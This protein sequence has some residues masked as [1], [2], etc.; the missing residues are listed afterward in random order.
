MRNRLHNRRMTP[1]HASSTARHASWWLV[2]CLAGCGGSP[3]ADP[4]VA[5][6]LRALSDRDGQIEWQAMLPCADCDGI[7]SQLVLRRAG[8]ASEYTLSET[9][10][11]GDQGA[12]FLEHGQWQQRHDLLHL[13]G[14][15]GSQRVYALLPDGRLQQRDGRGRPLR[16]PRAAAT[17]MPV[18][19]EPD[20]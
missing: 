3:P 17:L 2:A 19:L 13:R 11:V 12:R 18:S 6:P 10:L 1:A 4:P 14:D 15:G 8:R 5:P 7:A 16:L 20:R 9:Y